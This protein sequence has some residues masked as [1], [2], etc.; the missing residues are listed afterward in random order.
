MRKA[1]PRTGGIDRKG[2]DKRMEQGHENRRSRTVAGYVPDQKSPALL[3]DPAILAEWG[4]VVKIA[5]DD[6]EGVIAGG[7]LDAGDS[8][9][10]IRQQGPLD[11]GYL[12]H[13]G[14]DVRVGQPQL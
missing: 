11:S 1:T 7:Y 3:V 12:L 13:L 5:P 10:M 8:R 4:K 9:Q 2:M 14:L 6:V